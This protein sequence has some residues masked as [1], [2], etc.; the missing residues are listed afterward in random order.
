MDNG[1]LFF[2]LHFL[3]A[4]SILLLLKIVRSDLKN[5]FYLSFSTSRRPNDLPV[6]GQAGVRNLVLFIESKN[7][8]SLRLRRIEMTMIRYF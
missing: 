4:K 6:S 2:L 7:K 8:I 3:I 1:Q 5:E